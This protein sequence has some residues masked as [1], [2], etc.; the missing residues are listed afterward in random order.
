MLRNSALAKVGTEHGDTRHVGVP[1]GLLGLLACT[2]LL[3]QCSVATTGHAKHVDPDAGVTYWLP[4]GCTTR[5]G[6][7]L[8]CDKILTSPVGHDRGILLYAG[9][10]TGTPLD[11]LIQASISELASRN[12]SFRVISRRPFATSSG[13]AGQRIVTASG[14]GDKAVT[15]VMYFF[16]HGFNK[17]AFVGHLPSG[18]A[19]ERVLAELDEIVRRVVFNWQQLQ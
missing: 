14:K 8:E 6:Q 19:S 18:P 17:P 3:P 5:Q 10:V 16:G 1:C 12:A 9:T 4:P 2:V 7:G 11:E 15:G 13:I